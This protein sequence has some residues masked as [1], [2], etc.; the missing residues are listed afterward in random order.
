VAKKLTLKRPIRIL[1]VDD[2]PLIRE[3]LMA[4]LGNQPDMEVCGQAESEDD[5]LRQV[6]QLSPDVMIVDLS[7]KSGSGIGLIGRVRDHY[8]NVRMI[9][10]SVHDESL[11]TERALRAGAMGY[12]NKQEGSEQIVTAIRRVM[13]GEVC[14]S[15]KMSKRILARFSTGRADIDRSPLERLSDRELQVF[16]LIGQGLPT[17]R[18][19]DSLNLSPRTVDRHREN[20]KHKLN[21]T[22]ATQLIQ[23]ATQ[24]ALEN[25]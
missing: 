2:H 11:F 23:Y 8:K 6:Q 3:G 16:A 17:R 5:A 9:V 14:L 20:I 18:I 4:L 1:L 21:L 12:V 10:S 13:Q 24:W 15:D 19:A 7:L 22:S 25:K